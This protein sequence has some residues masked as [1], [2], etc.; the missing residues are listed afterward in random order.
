MTVPADPALTADPVIEAIPRREDQ[1]RQRG[2][3]LPQPPQDV[4]AIAI[5]Q[6]EVKNQQ[7]VGLGQ[8]GA[9]RETGGRRQRH[10]KAAVGEAQRQTVSQRGIVFDEEN[11][12]GLRL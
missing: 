9:V 12:H 7:I 11:L 10:G 4:Q 1:Y 2:L 5:G 6:A 3:A 8:Q